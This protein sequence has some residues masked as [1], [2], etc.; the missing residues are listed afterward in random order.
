M[1]PTRR[2]PDGVLTN[3]ALGCLGAAKALRT[4]RASWVREAYAAYGDQGPLISGI[5]RDHWPAELKDRLRVN[6]RA[7]TQAMDDAYKIWRQAGR[8]VETIR[9]LQNDY[10][11]D[12]S[13][14]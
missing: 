10:R 6:A 9:A 4:T 14:Y 2:D 8:R 7:I 3:Q 5:E 1:K 12:G 11:V 13:R